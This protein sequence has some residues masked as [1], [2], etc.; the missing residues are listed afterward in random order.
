ME[1]R[2]QIITGVENEN[3]G[4]P[5]VPWRPTYAQGCVISL[6]ITLFSVKGAHLGFTGDW[7]EVR[8]II[9]ESETVQCVN[10]ST[11]RNIAGHTEDRVKRERPGKPA[12]IT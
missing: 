8:G 6:I 10:S 1:E 12:S 11:C 3:T 7:E 5:A 4:T 9:R 2:K